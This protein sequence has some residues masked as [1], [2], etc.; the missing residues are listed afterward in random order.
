MNWS[1]LV[2]LLGGMRAPR[3]AAGQGGDDNGVF[4]A[5]QTVQEVKQTNDTCAVPGRRVGKQSCVVLSQNTRLEL[6]LRARLV[7]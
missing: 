1:L 6:I 3:V 4:R 2:W 7:Y 5:M